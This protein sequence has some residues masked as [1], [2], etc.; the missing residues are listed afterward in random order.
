MRVAQAKIRQFLVHGCL[1][2]LAFILLV[3]FLFVNPEKNYLKEIL[4]LVKEIL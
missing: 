4:F 3:L 2:I 1:P